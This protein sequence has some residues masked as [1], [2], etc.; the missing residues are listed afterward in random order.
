MTSAT[1]K[2][3]QGVRSS[4][5][6]LYWLELDAWMVV[7]Q[8]WEGLPNL[9]CVDQ[10]L[11]SSRSFRSNLAILDDSSV[12]LFQ[13]NMAWRSTASKLLNLWVLSH[14]GKASD[15]FKERETSDFLECHQ[16]GPHPWNGG[17]WWRFKKIKVYGPLEEIGD[18]CSF[19]G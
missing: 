9:K 19:R 4:G 3:R 10:I 5:P 17:C 13:R 8:G 14:G 2:Q 7:H 15:F 11:L 18:D 12:S 16:G 1:R 6:W